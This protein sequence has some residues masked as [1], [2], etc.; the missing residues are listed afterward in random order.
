MATSEVFDHRPL[1][2]IGFRTHFT[3]YGLHIAVRDDMVAEAGGAGEHL[4][5]DG[6]GVARARV[7]RAQVTEHVALV[8]V[9]AVTEGTLDEL[10]LR[11]MYLHVLTQRART[12]EQFGTYRTRLQ[13]LSRMFSNVIC[14]LRLLHKRLAAVHT[15]V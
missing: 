6:A 3:L 8:L 11:F 12:C 10:L 7:A 9:L 2:R 13:V 15:R 4:V 1:N 14:E 5:T